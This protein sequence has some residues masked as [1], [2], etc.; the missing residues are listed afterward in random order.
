MPEVA[1]SMATA[2]QLKVISEG[3]MQKRNSGVVQ[4]KREFDV[5]YQPEV[6]IVGNTK[7]KDQKQPGQEKDKKEDTFAV[8]IPNRR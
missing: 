8:E 6:S 1:Q 7:D 5:I 3:R 2:E 4:A